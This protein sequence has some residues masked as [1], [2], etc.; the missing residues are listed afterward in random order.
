MSDLYDNTTDVHGGI[1]SAD[2]DRI[3]AGLSPLARPANHKRV[4]IVGAG[5]SGMSTAIAILREQ[6]KA[7][8]AG[9]PA[10]RVD[11]T[12][13][14]QQ[15]NRFGGGLAYSPEN[16]PE[17]FTNIPARLISAIDDE[18]DHFVSWL[19]DLRDNGW[20]DKTGS[21][22]VSPLYRG[23]FGPHNI[24]PRALYGRYLRDTLQDLT[25]QA[26]SLGVASVTN[27]I[28]RVTAVDEVADRTVLE[29]DGGVREFDNVVLSTGHIE[30]RNLRPLRN[31]SDRI[32]DRVVT[33]SEQLSG[34]TQE[35]LSGEHGPRVTVIGSGLSAYDRVLTAL[36]NGFFD[37]P[38]AE[39]T[40]LSRRGHTH[41]SMPAQPFNVP[42]IKIEDLPTPPF[43]VGEVPRYL[44]E[45]YRDYRS[46]GH[47][48]W[49]ITAALQP[50]APE[51]IERSGIPASFLAPLMRDHG[52]I[53]N[54]TA[55][56]VGEETASKV[57]ALIAQGRVQLV[58]GSIHNVRSSIR[59]RVRIDYTP[60]GSER[61]RRLFCD[62]VVSA[63]GPGNDYNQTNH[64]IYR[65]MLGRGSAR[66]HEAS[67]IGL[68]VDPDTRCVI[69]ENGQAQ[70]RIHAIGPITAGQVAEKEGRFG[71]LGQNIPI[72]RKHA[73]QIASAVA[74]AAALQLT[75]ANDADG[76]DQ[77][78]TRSGLRAWLD[79]R[80]GN[81]KPTAA[82]QSEHDVNLA[83]RRPFVRYL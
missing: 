57:E 53:I 76:G 77:T 38:R 21:Q 46:Q 14:E 30:F 10:S 80:F 17:H 51:L 54:T 28:G 49:E 34:R 43:T 2:L 41:P 70:S 29:V 45:I 44:T 62:G 61:S 40:L 68:E 79:R 5:F 73:Q 15:R 42:D 31:V 66:V 75:A 12:L 60:N 69:A 9:A 48:D 24:V 63:L 52:S 19:Q 25:N 36:R 55:I 71:P 11:V 35:I 6:I 26:E 13:F 4:G 65:R 23:R 67:G 39:M 32:A 33:A 56:G 82:N 78:V 59:G 16:G 47:K 83:A 18:P 1:N 64:P 37:N 58:S 50:L 3:Y 7:H 74:P 20:R 27:H 81:A 22:P 72:L 8:E